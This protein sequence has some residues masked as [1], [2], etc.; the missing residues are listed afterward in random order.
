[1]NTSTPYD[2]KITDFSEITDVRDGLNPSLRKTLF[3]LK[4]M[5][6]NDRFANSSRILKEVANVIGSD[7]ESIYDMLVDTTWPRSD[8]PYVSGHGNFG[9]P[10]AYPDYSEMKLTNFGRIIVGRAHDSDFSLP[11]ILPVPYALACGT[12]GYSQW[13]KTKIPSH[14]SREV[15]DAMIALVKNP[16]L[17]TKD[18]LEFIKGPDLLLGGAIENPE[19]LPIIYEKGFGNINVIVTPQN[20]NMRFNDGLI[21]YCDWY[22]LKFRKVYK[23]DAYRIKLPYYAFMSDGEKCELMSLEKI[24]KKHLD[25]YRTYKGELSNDELCQLLTSLKEQLSDRKTYEK[26]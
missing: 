26:I 9:F 16:D 15:I 3:V 22:G 17:E 5:Y 7:F 8:L 6:T 19:E 23:K 21:D 20:F 13:C 10:P 12:I 14:N 18:L 2:F 1:M 11:F 24:L 4:T 25:Y